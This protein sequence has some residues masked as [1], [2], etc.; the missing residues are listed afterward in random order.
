[1]KQIQI[2]SI[3]IR[4]FKGIKD[5]T[6]KAEGNDVEV[7]GDNDAGKTTIYDAFLWCLFHKD[8]KDRSQFKW[9]PLDPDNN[10]IHGLQTSVTV[11]LLIDGKSK[12]FH[13]EI[14]ETKR[15]RRKTKEVFYEDVP[16]YYID[17]LEISTKTQYDEL[18]SEIVDQQKFKNL[19]SVTYFCEQLSPEERRLK[20]ADNGSL[21]RSKELI[22]P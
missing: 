21:N 11:E 5:F 9:K 2:K 17:A 13:K 14:N 1:M 10:Y 20:I 3:A 15:T 22:Q 12:E 6:L 16:K 19:T 4:N 18:V 8:S 7:S